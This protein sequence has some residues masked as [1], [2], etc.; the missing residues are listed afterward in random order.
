MKAERLKYRKL[1]KAMLM[2][3]IHQFQQQICN[4]KHSHMSRYQQQQ[5]KLHQK[6]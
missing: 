1:V 5:Q 6:L 4:T 2:L 3:F